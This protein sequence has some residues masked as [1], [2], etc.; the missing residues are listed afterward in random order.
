MTLR[1]VDAQGRPLG[2]VIATFT[3]ASG[4]GMI[5]TLDQSLID[6][7]EMT[8]A[9]QTTDA[10]GQA[11]VRTWRLGPNAGPNVVRAT[12]GNVSIDFTINGVAR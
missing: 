3:V 4:G 5:T 9:A 10:N 11:M 7:T 2:N 6:Q 1:V 8:T 12:V